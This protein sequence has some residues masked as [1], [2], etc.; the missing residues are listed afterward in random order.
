MAMCYNLAM[1]SSILKIEIH[2]RGCYLPEGG[3]LPTHGTRKGRH[4]YHQAFRGT[5]VQHQKSFHSTGSGGV[6]ID[7]HFYIL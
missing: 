1:N 5:P 4:Q 3:L 7:S 6:Q 2:M